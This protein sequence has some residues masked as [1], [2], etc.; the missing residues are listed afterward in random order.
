M[1]FLLQCQI[2]KYVQDI[3]LGESEQKIIFL[4]VNI[5]K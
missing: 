1:S 4:Y 3:T 5:S 2:Q